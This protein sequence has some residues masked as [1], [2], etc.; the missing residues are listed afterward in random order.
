MEARERAH[1]GCFAVQRSK[2]S[3]CLLWIGIDSE[4]LKGF[5]VVQIAAVSIFLVI[6]HFFKTLIKLVKSLLKECGTNI[7]NYVE[8]I[9]LILNLQIISSHAQLIA[10]ARH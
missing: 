3:V 8:I 6:K 5:N 7:F 4:E 1:P 2:W 10:V 9:I